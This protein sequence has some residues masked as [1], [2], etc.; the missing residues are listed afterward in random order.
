MTTRDEIVR[1]AL[2][3]SA[4]ERAVLA[5]RLLDSLEPSNDATIDPEWAAEIVRR[6]AAYDRGELESISLDELAAQLQSRRKSA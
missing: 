1:Q 6:I 3:L 4:D 2:A 5:N